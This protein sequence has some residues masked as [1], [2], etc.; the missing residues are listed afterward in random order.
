MSKRKR[1]LL[2][3][4]S[5]SIG[6][7]LLHQ[8]VELDAYDIT[9]FDLAKRQVKRRLNKFKN[10]V[11]IH[12]GDIRSQEAVREVCTNIDVVLH[13]AAVLPPRA[14]E[15]A[16][17]AQEVNVEGTANLVAALHELSPKVFF[18]YTSSIAAYG[19]R[20]ENP[21]IT[22]K[23]LPKASL[24]D[25]Y[26]KTKLKAEELLKSSSLSWSILRLTA[27]MGDHGLSKLMFHMP[28]DT[29]M[30]I[31]TIEDTARALVNTINQQHQL[32]G[33]VFNLSGGES[34][35]TSYL[36]FLK[37]S[38]DIAG[39]GEFDFP[40]KTFAE[41]NFHCGYY[42]DGDELNE[43]LSFQKDSL[44]DYFSKECA[45]ISPIQ[46]SL[47]HLFRKP[48]KSY[49]K[50]LSEPLHAYH[51]GDERLIEQFFGTVEKD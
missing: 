34:C 8:L 14:D 39:L 28:L 45:K 36:D 25:N 4:A 22:V 9:V 18:V 13:L 24:G 7:E 31:A 23:D 48:I 26:A 27:I 1:V 38:F 16:A 20:L 17:Y 12:Y 44:E 35:R 49:L 50:S 5:G 29:L 51:S 37:R 21:M 46:K 42:V 47:T 6:Y 2:T 11:T 3:G 33:K 19:D 15:E 10:K 40:D 32:H 30:E 43:I 41:K